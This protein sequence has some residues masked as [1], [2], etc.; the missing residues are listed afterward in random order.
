M[1]NYWAE[2]MA[3]AQTAI[4]DKGIAEIEAQLTKYYATTQKK[5]IGQFE[6]TYNHILSSL[7]EGRQITPADLYKLDTY[8]RMEAQ[9]RAELQKL[10]YQQADLLGKKF[11]EE[12]ENIYRGI[13]INDNLFF[14][15]IDTQAAQQMINSVWCADGQ[16]W[17]D[18]VWNNVGK[19]QATLN[20]GLI[21]CVVAGRKTSELK[22]VLQ[23][24][25]GVSY[26][27]AS[28]LVRTE[29]SHIQTQAARERY[30][31]AGLTEVEV[32]ADYDERRCDVCG[33]LH[34]TKHPINGDMPIPAHP[35]CRCCII[36]VLN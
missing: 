18:R 13:E 28:T 32:W 5:I 34:K 2:R 26:K 23:E 31:N 29:M 27:Q 25:F 11:N 17:S 30:R 4:T 22:Q 21:D 20:E 35:N 14:G 15:E 3:A 33:E 24:R 7:A 12:W 6:Q 36:P 8:W 16:T 10:G 19:L 1:S 9:V